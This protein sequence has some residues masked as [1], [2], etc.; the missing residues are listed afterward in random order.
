MYPQENGKVHAHVHD[1]YKM[2]KGGKVEK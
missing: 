1:F 2:S